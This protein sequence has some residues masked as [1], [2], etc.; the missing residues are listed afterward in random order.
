[1]G[2]SKLIFY[3]VKYESQNPFVLVM[4]DVEQGAG[5][6]GPASTRPASPATCSARCA[7]IAATS[8]TWPWK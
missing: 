2:S 1:M 7:A 4:G 6:A 3:G 8:C 5:A